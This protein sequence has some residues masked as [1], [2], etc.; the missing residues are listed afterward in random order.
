MAIMRALKLTTVLTTDRHFRQVGFSMLPA[1][2]VSGARKPRQ[3]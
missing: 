2:R 1:S 3:S